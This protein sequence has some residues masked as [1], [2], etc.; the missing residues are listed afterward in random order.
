V[1]VDEAPRALG[2]RA[3]DPDILTA[4]I[5]ERQGVTDVNYSGAASAFG[6][7]A[8]TTGGVQ[9]ALW[10]AAIPNIDP[11]DLSQAWQTLSSIPLASGDRD[12]VAARVIGVSIDNESADARASAATTSEANL[13]DLDARGVAWP[14]EQVECHGTSSARAADSTEG[15][16]VVCDVRAGHAEVAADTVVRRFSVPV[17][18]M[19]IGAD[20]LATAT[21]VIRSPGRGTVARSSAVVR[22]IDLFGRVRIGE[23]RA[24]AETWAF[25]RKG[26]A[27]SSYERALLDVWIDTDGDGDADVTCASCDARA[28][29]PDINRALGGTAVVRMPDPDAA[30]HPNGS[31]GGYQSVVRRD[32]FESLAASAL[33]SDD[34]PEVPGLEVIAYADGRAG[35][36]RQIFQFAAVEAESRY[37][38][39]LLPSETEQAPTRARTIRKTIVPPAPPPARVEPGVPP[40]VTRDVVSE[41]IRRV[42][43]GWRLA[44][45]SPR[46]ALLL[47]AL[48]VFLATPVSVIARRRKLERLDG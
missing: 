9:R 18:A 29:L 39:Y 46:D 47:G 4:G 7:R 40:T 36:S 10:N 13:E 2:V 1:L 27:G 37:G 35:R 26:T 43:D 34:A 8:L 44:L 12:L 15:A 20:V 41:V 14:Y 38:I 11:E 33:N 24:R 48:W 23:L 31:P 17:G 16:A 6:A 19:S 22:D 30:F 5:E 42:R 28:L 32:I 25:G 3:L 21:Q 45:S